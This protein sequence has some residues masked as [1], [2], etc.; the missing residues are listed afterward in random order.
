LALSKSALGFVISHVHACVSGQKRESDSHGSRVRE[1]WQIY[2]LSRMTV[3]ADAY[4]TPTA[5]KHGCERHEQNHRNSHSDIGSKGA[6][7]TAGC[8]NSSRGRARLFELHRLERI[9]ND[10]T[11]HVFPPDIQSC[12]IQCILTLRVFAYTDGHVERKRVAQ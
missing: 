11:E 1:H 4:A 5:Q 8:I 3:R 6:Q 12:H 9:M 7:R 2:L 10:P